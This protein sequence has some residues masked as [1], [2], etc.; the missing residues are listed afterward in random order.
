MQ[1]E[2]N[3]LNKYNI[4]NSKIIIII[5]PTIISIAVCSINFL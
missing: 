5:A 1:L 2:K 4:I 3:Y